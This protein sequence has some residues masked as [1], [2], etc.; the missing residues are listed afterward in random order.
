[1]RRASLAFIL[2]LHLPATVAWLWLMPGGWPFNS[3]RFWVNEVAPVVV[4]VTTLVAIIA[5]V[6]RRDRL[7]LSL[8]LP[9][10]GMWLAAS[11]AALFVFPFSGWLI[12]IRLAPLAVLM[13]L[14]LLPFR[15]AIRRSH[16]AAVLIGLIIGPL[17]MLTERGAAPGT[18]PLNIAMPALPADASYEPLSVPVGTFAR[19]SSRSGDLQFTAG[20]LLVELTPLLT[21]TSCSP[22][23]G[24]VNFAAPHDRTPPHRMLERISLNG[25]DVIARYTPEG[26]LHL[27]P[28]DMHN[29]IDVEAFTALAS[30]IYSHL[31]T[32][33][34]LSIAGHKRLAIAFSPCPTAKIDVTYYDYPFGR[35]ATFACLG[36]D[37]IF[38]I[39]RAT[40]SEK[41][42]FSEIA[43]GPLSRGDPLGITLFDEDRASIRL[44]FD[45]WSS[46]LSTQPSPTA[47]WNV[48]ANAIEFSLMSDNPRSPAGI[49]M[50][51]AATSV[52][53]GFDSVGHS[54][55]T[56]R[57]RIH[58]E[59]LDVSIPSR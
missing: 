32:F 58:V 44:T 49:Y 26:L 51:L 31:N 11:I 7:V 29:A 38:R 52:G 1:M 37:G 55:G 6:T 19:F 39:L 23:A 25:H 45:D 41:G 53:R 18:H 33:C 54:A 36:A 22:D 42:P 9:I 3:G 35:P 40:N 20:P 4:F 10:V 28:D 12:S 14:S 5:L 2:A 24:W 48:P 27:A 47:G 17:V 13:V 30:P 46:Q 15:A 16:I 56:Y 43:S 34:E 21:F 8:V 59:R 50:T 57:N